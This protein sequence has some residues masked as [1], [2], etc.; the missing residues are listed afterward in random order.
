MTSTTNF[1]YMTVLSTDSYIPGVIKLYKSLMVTRPQYPFVCACSRNISNSSIQT[2]NKSGIKCLKLERCAIDNITSL[3]NDENF[4]HWKYTYDKLLLFSL[5]Q[6]KKIVYLDSDMLIL[7]N[8]DELFDCLPFSA[9]PAGHLINK[10]WIRLNSGLMVIEPDNNTMEIMLKLIAPVYQKRKAQGL[11]TGDQ[12]IINEYI[13]DWFH[14][15]ELVLPESYNLFFNYI[16]IY[17]KQYKFKYHNPCKSRTIKVVHFIG[18]NKPW[19]ESLIKRLLLSVKYILQR[20]YG[21]KAYL[22]YIF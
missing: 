4:S 12:D 7:E 9:V 21:L 20:N 13:Q 14:N 16:D 18:K 10:D 5:T 2:L 17:R 1:V 8:I 22:R 19:N 3:E 11:A 15:K 6:F